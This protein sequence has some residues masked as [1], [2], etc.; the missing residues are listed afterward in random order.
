MQKI[1]YAMMI[2]IAA[3]LGGRGIAAT[4]QRIG[5]GLQ[6]TAKQASH[7]DWDVAQVSCEGDVIASSDAC[8]LSVPMQFGGCGSACCI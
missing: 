7:I 1:K 5:S 3:S 4:S 2:A 8:D 6:G